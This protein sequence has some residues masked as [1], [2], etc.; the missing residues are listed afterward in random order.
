MQKVETMTV[1]LPTRFL[2]RY[3]V[4]KQLLGKFGK[5]LLFPL[6]L[7]QIDVQRQ[8]GVSVKRKC[9]FVAV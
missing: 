8:S 5:L 3:S 7:F 2:S 9:L 1:P 6:V 4:G